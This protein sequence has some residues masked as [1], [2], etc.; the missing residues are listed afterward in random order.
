MVYRVLWDLAVVA[1][2]AAATWVLPEIFPTYLA[3]AFA[4]VMGIT[5]YKIERHTY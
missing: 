2:F 4:A 1:A 5:R 3:I